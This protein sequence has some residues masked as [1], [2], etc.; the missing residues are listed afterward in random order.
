VEK[1]K[2]SQEE[3]EKRSGKK[4]YFIESVIPSGGM[5]YLVLK[6]LFD[7]LCSFCIIVALLPWCVLIAV[8]IFI[9][10][11]GNPIYVQE[12]VGKNGKKF[13]ILKFRTM[14]KNAE[15]DGAMWALEDDSRCTSS[16]KILRKYRIDEIPQLLNIFLG[17]MSFVGPRPERQVFYDHF[18]TYIHGFSN[19]LSVTPGLTGWAQVSGGYY[20]EPEEKIRYDMEYIEKRSLLFDLKILFKTVKLVVTSKGEER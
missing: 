6:R 5:G 3:L 20:L 19:R 8:I 17:H 9:D 12:R 2:L 1:I 10:S 7:I 11:P 15:E 14:V 4:E 13:M 16:G 18:E